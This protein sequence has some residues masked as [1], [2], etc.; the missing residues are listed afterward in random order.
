[1]AAI[2]FVNESIG[3]V[4]VVTLVRL[5]GTLIRR[6]YQ[7][8]ACPPSVAGVNR[9]GKRSR[10][11]SLF[12]QALLADD[13]ELFRGPVAGEIPKLAEHLLLVIHCFGE[14]EIFDVGVRT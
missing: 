14:V 8:F 13:C 7:N 2:I 3:R 12:F 11:I 6:I 5:E 4:I 1:M 10:V 9:R